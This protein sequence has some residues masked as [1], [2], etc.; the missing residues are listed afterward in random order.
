MIR[1]AA[2]PSSDAP[3]HCRNQQCPT[4]NLQGS[5]F[6]FQHINTPKIALGKWVVGFFAEETELLVRKCARYL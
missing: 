6:F 4:E 3:I 1:G 5:L 2:V